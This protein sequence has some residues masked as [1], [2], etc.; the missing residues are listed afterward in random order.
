MQWFN[1][2][3]GVKLE[4]SCAITG[5]SIPS[6]ARDIVQ[7]HL[8][9]YDFW[10]LNGLMFGVEAVKS[11]ILALACV[12]RQISVDEGVRLATLETVYQVQTFYFIDC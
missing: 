4:P 1:N 12:D 3:Y 11:V 2:R 6:R 9:S 5:P 10:S 7:K 8:H